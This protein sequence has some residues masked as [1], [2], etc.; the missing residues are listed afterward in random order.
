M[1]Y[2]SALFRCSPA[3][4]CNTC[5]E[6]V[7]QSA[8]VRK[9]GMALNLRGVPEEVPVSFRAVVEEFDLRWDLQTDY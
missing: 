4:N 7:P 5:T 3:P 6:N 8:G 2:T 1:A 9:V